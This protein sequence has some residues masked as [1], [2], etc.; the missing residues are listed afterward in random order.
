MVPLPSGRLQGNK[1]DFLEAAEPG[2][3]FAGPLPPAALHHRPLAGDRLVRKI[4]ALEDDVPPGIEDGHEPEVLFLGV[5]SDI[6]PAQ[7]FRL[8]LVVDLARHLDDLLG[9][10]YLRGEDLFGQGTKT[11]PPAFWEA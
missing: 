2:E 11:L 9:E 5:L 7:M 8:P 10:E 4:A 6:A 1:T 3:K